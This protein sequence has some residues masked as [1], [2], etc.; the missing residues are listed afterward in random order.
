MKKL[1]T[2]FFL[3]MLSGCVSYVLVPPQKTV[4]G[5]IE[6]EPG[7]A[8]TALRDNIWTIDGQRL[9]RLN[10]IT[11]ASGDNILTGT[12]GELAPQ[13]FRFHRDMTEIE[14]MDL[15]VNTLATGNNGI[16][17]TTKNLKKFQFVGGD[18]IR[19]EY[20]LKEKDGLNKS[21]IV[22]IRVIGGWLFAILYEGE[23]LYYYHKTLEEA[24][25]IIASAKIRSK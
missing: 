17:P 1:I 5:G 12:K 16:P 18:G 6:V 25:R 14:L 24:E 7:L 22:A 8:W 2:I 20:N 21:V 13:A 15:F 11:L 4:V 19:F 10:F 9:Q 23:S 3:A